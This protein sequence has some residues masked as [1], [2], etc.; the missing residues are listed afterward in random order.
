[1][2]KPKSYDTNYKNHDPTIKYKFNAT[3]IGKGSFAF[4]FTGQDSDGSTY[5]I[6]QID[7]KKLDCLRLDKFSLELEISKKLDHINIV[8]C[9]D[10]FKT[11]DHWYIVS[12]YC[13]GGTLYDAYS[14]L[15]KLSNFDREILVKT[16]L[17]QL[18]DALFYLKQHHIIHR[19][20]K[21]Q[22]ILISIKN[23]DEIIKLADFG[24]AKYFNK[25]QIESQ[26]LNSTICGSPI[27][28]APEMLTKCKYNIKADLWSF[29][30][31]MYE[32]LVGSNPYNFPQNVSELRQLMLE[33]PIVFPNF[34]SKNCIDLLKKL[35]TFEASDR[36][37]WDD[38][39]VHH[40][41]TE[42]LNTPQFDDTNI[43]FS[44]MTPTIA[45][46][47]YERIFEFDD[48]ENLKNKFQT[49]NFLNGPNENC[50]R[51]GVNNN[52]FNNVNDSSEISDN[53]DYN[54]D[55][56][57]DSDNDLV[58]VE[59][60]E[61]ESIPIPNCKIYESQRDHGSQGNSFIKILSDSFRYLF[62]R[63]QSF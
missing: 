3:P 40:W 55:D 14:K 57:N 44:K 27:Y 1:M 59:N 62:R 22:N 18:K 17:S 31:I 38:F 51:I 8:K 63:P 30:I 41:F 6:K 48:E 42:K 61:I 4:V 11:S 29:G 46:A 24:L 60:S 35:L 32:M 36:I 9:Y 23:N 20:L 15:S 58:I 54:D 2:I 16:Y 53:D 37:G 56:N 5:A 12:E 33:R 26:D 52:H 21:P 47:I 43:F 28:M 13:D 39:F 7:L 19:D 45:D 25:Q 50:Q 49:V 34:F 10:T